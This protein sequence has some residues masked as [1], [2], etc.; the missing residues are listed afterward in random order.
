MHVAFV[1]NFEICRL[2]TE[3]ETIIHMLNHKI[4]Y[5]LLKFE[6]Q[7][8]PKILSN[9]SMSVCMHTISPYENKN[10]EPTSSMQVF[11][12]WVMKI[13]SY[14]IKKYIK[15]HKEVWSVILL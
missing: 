11:L 2:E 6:L 5:L 12:C 15:K 1:D 14:A 13:C 4:Y 8:T 3:E 7:H 10:N 9:F